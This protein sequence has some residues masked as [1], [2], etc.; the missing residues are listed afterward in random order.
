M[1]PPAAATDRHSHARPELVRVEHVEVDLTADFASRELHGTATLH[2][3]R[4]DAGA[5]LIVDVGRGMTIESIVGADGAARPHELS[6]ADPILGRA[7]TITLAPGDRSV[8]IRYRTGHAA[9]A[10]QWLAPAQTAGGTQPYLYTQGQAILTRTW[11]PL[12]DSP[13][14]RVTWTAVIRTD[15][16][17]VALMSADR[18]EVES[19]GTTRFAMSHAVPPYLIALAIGDLAKRDVSARCAIWTE[20]AMLDRAADELCDVERMLQRCEELYGEYVWGRY[21]VLVLPPAFPFGGMENPCLT[22]ATPTILAGDRSLVALIAHELAHSW[23]GNLVTNAT[24][25][26][27]WLN[28]GFT[29]Y[30]EQRIVE[31]LYGRER[32]ALE[33]HLCVGELRAELAKLEPCDQVLHVDLDGRDPDLGMTSVPYHK[34]AAFLRRLERAFGR[35]RFDAFLGRWFASHAFRSVTTADFLAFLSTE[36]LQSDP[37]AARGIDVDA[38]I[39]APGLPADLALPPSTRL[40]AVDAARDAWLA[41]GPTAALPM[42]GWTTAETLRFLDDLGAGAPA[43]R[44]DELDAA[45]ELTGSHNAEILAAWLERR[46]LAGPLPPRVDARLEGFLLA[47]GRRKLVRPLYTALLASEAG[48]ARAR[49]IYASARP[50]YHAVTRGTLDALL[51]ERAPNAG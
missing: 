23:S 5:P 11:I 30:V 42:P 40:A 35:D 49:A 38:W 8:T 3:V 45:F 36:L 13:G 4:P 15:P 39:H 18:R 29:V 31:A 19:A 25:S 22:F 48:A 28:E 16:A 24:W 21:D 12:Q 43:A 44:L 9:A 47:V 27:F 14:T 26:D 51:T 17:L 34:G 33:I 50:R 20:P 1:E 46:I 6:G 7:L 10:V 32:A 2:V 41:G 37:A